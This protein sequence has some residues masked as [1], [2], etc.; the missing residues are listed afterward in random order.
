MPGTNSVMVCTLMLPAPIP[1]RLPGCSRWRRPTAHRRY[2]H[3]THTARLRL[4]AGQDA[5]LC[6]LRGYARW[7][8]THDMTGMT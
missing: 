1:Q 7:I 5:G 4:L 6:R 8:R 2:H 3:T